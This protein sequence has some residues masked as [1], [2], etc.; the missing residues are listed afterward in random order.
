MKFLAIGCKAA[1]HP[2]NLLVAPLMH[3]PTRIEENHVVNKSKPVR[4]ESRALTTV[5]WIDIKKRSK[6][7]YLHEEKRINSNN[8]N[9]HNV[10]E[11]ILRDK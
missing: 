11:D 2:L 8:Q 3:V 1:K 7:N 9:R 4:L 10:L 5:Q 6:E